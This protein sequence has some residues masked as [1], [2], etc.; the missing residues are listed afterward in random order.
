[1]C[2]CVCAWAQAPVQGA[3]HAKPQ[4]ASDEGLGYPLDAYRLSTHTHDGPCDL[5]AVFKRPG[6]SGQGEHLTPEHAREEGLGGG[7]QG[8]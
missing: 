3:Y 8:K 6:T 2:M 7:E 4:V 5:Q 1:M